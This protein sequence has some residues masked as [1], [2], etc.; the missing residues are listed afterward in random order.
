VIDEPHVVV[1]QMARQQASVSGIPFIHPY[2]DADVVAGQGTAGIEIHEQASNR[3]LDLRATFVAVGGGGL[4]SGIGTALKNL[5]PGIDIVGCWAANSTGLYQSLKAGEIVEVEEGETIA[6]GVTGNVEPGSITL[7]IARDVITAT[8]LASEEE[9]K[10]AMRVLAE[11]DRWMVEG[12]A[13]VAVASMLR[14]APRYKDRAVVAVLCGRN[15]MLDKYILA[16][17]H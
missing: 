4:I 12:A 1:E 13:G 5:H 16:V 14:L 17:Q 8:D 11:T 10:S 3:G 7:K 15:I 9:I 6:D 2:N